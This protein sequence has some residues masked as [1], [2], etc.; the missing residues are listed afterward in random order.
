MGELQKQPLAKTV[1][2]LWGIVFLAVVFGM[3]AYRL[4]AKG[5]G[6]FKPQE[7]SYYFA[8]AVL[9]VLGAAKAE[10]LFRRKFV[11]RTLARGRDA[12]NS[13]LDY[14]LAPFCMLS[15]YRPW[16]V[17]HAVL[18]WA[19]VPIMVTLAVLFARQ[20]PIPDGAFKGGVDVAIGLALAVTAA[21]YLVCAFRLLAWWTAGANAE[22]IPLPRRE[23]VI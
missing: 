14:I 10:F 12:L 13:T 22:T 9:L 15:F 19:I 2:Q 7:A 16:S 18:S 23:Q 11:P 5:F 3:G 8:Y 17:K 1:G 20:E 6:L 21:I 4:T